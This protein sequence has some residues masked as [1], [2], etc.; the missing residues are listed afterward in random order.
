MQ[1][2]DH[3]SEKC[4]IDRVAKCPCDKQDDRPA[5]R[6]LFLEVHIEKKIAKDG[7]GNHCDNHEQEL[8]IL[9]H[10]SG[11]SSVFPIRDVKHMGNP[12]PIGIGQDYKS[13]RQLFGDLVK[14]QQDE[15]G[16]GTECHHA[17]LKDG[18]Q[19]NNPY[20]QKHECDDGTFDKL[21]NLRVD[22]FDCGIIVP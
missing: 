13:L 4:T 10:R 12:D 20:D 21:R 5:V 9:K 14:K 22:V 1:K 7:K 19:D 18:N 6:F 17:L 8:L 16:Y 11:S 15:Y 3:I 2:V